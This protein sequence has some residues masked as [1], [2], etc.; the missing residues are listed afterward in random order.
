MFQK[1]SSKGREGDV[2]LAI[3]GCCTGQTHREPQVHPGWGLSRIWEGGAGQGV[4]A[5]PANTPGGQQRPQ[6]CLSMWSRDRPTP[7]WAEALSASSPQALPP[8]QPSCVFPEAR[9]QFCSLPCCLSCTHPSSH[10]SPPSPSLPLSPSR[11][12]PDDRA[13]CPSEVSAAAIYITC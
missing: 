10:S 7:V 8:H 3:S 13:L 12:P 6:N 9:G 1:R 2:L 5:L 4:P 11:E